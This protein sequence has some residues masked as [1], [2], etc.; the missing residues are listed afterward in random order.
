MVIQLPTWLLLGASIGFV[1]WYLFF[2]KDKHKIPPLYNTSEIIVEGDAQPGQEGK[3]DSARPS[4]PS[5]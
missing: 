3:D 4:K 5:A 2:K 1:I